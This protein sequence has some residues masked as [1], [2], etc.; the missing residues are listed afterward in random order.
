[1]FPKLTQS[2]MGHR[3]DNT[4]RLTHDNDT[5]MGFLVIITI[6]YC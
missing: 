6:E 4:S 1:M 3:Q 5:M 2:L